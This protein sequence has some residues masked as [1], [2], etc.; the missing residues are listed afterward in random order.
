MTKSIKRLLL[1][2][3]P[4]QVVTC[5]SAMDASGE[6]GRSYEDAL[7]IIHPEIPQRSKQ[8]IQEFARRLGFA[9]VFDFS[10]EYGEILKLLQ[11]TTSLRRIPFAGRS[12]F[13]KRQLRITDLLGGIEDELQ[14]QG[15]LRPDHVF[16]RH[17]LSTVEGLVLSNTFHNRDLYGIEDGI[18]DYYYGAGYSAARLIY[19]IPRMLKQLAVWAIYSTKSMHWRRNSVGLPYMYRMQKRFSNLPYKGNIVVGDYFKRNL[20]KVAVDAGSTKG[21][22]VILGSILD[23]HPKY[24][25]S[26]EAEVAMYNKLIEQIKQTH[27]VNREQIFYKPHPRISHA[28][29]AYKQQHLHCRLY[30]FDNNP[31]FETQLVNSPFKAA[32]SVGSTSLLVAKALF[33]LD[34]YLLDLRDKGVHPRDLHIAYDVL[35][36]FGVKP[37]SV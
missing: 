1:C 2:T 14:K 33:G 3:S 31:M 23:S 37:V 7:V 4:L 19:E 8:L 6:A 36:R 26:T 17:Y 18:G 28:S 11:G 25:L 5:R 30:P 24:R 35:T 12:E 10:K 22:V 16:V 29:W 34:S 9:Q 27:G 21:S 32:Y 13:Q 15:F 20:A